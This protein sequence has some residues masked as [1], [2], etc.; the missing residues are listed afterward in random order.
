MNPLNPFSWNGPAFLGFYAALA[1]AILGY[2]WLRT[3]CGREE[4]KVKLAEMTADPYRIACLRDGENEAIRVALFNLLDRGLLRFNGL[5][6]TATRT[7][8]AA[9]V[10]RSLDVKI[11]EA[12]RAPKTRDQLME[13]AAVRAAARA[14]GREL[15]VKGLFA[16]ADEEGMRTRL[17]FTAWAV[18]GVVAGA[19][20]A[21]AISQGQLRIGFLLIAAGVSCYLVFKMLARPITPAGAQVIRNLR[22]LVKRL[23][24]RV[25]SLASGGETNEAL[26]VASVYG[27]GILPFSAFPFLEGLF[28]RR[29]TNAEGASNFE[30]SGCGTSSSCDGSSGCGGSCGGGCGGCGSD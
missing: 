30:I 22:S 25:G 23:R 27:L 17:M 16:R 11:L 21:V 20:V 28:P 14:Y 18:L 10:R 6:L 4:P 3:R 13:H 15:A 9:L 29:A 1:L 24:E 19:K 2:C 8:S 7:D 12:C 26:L 5:A